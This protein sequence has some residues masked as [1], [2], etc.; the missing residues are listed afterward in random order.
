MPKKPDAPE[1]APEA[2]TPA[3]ADAAP[4]PPADAAPPADDS[5]EALR[6]RLVDAL[7]RYDRLNAENERLAMR[8]H[9]G[10]VALAERAVA[11]LE[12]QALAALVPQLRLSG[13]QASADKAIARAAALAD[14]DS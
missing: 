5:P 2:N 10:P 9:E 4:S 7:D 6:A 14:L 12:V 3:P 11:A 1:S 8:L 13:R